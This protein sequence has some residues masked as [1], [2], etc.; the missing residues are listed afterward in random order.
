MAPA[1][2]QEAL[3]ARG[4]GTPRAGARERLEGALFPHRQPNPCASSQRTEE[5]RA[6]Q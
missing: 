2:L 3:R 6:W 5:T 4:M 1:C